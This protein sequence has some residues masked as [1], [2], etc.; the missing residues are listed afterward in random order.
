MNSSLY[1]IFLYAAGTSLGSVYLSVG[2]WLSL[3]LVALIYILCYLLVL[4]ICNDWWC[5]SF[6]GSCD[7]ICLVWDKCLIDLE[8]ISMVVRLLNINLICF[9]IFLQLVLLVS[10]LK[11]RL[12]SKWPIHNGPWSSLTIRI[13]S[14]S[15]HSCV[16]CSRKVAHWCIGMIGIGA[17]M[18]VDQRIRFHRMILCILI[19]LRFW[20][21][22][23][24]TIILVER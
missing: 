22:L 11:V 19:E 5:H 1:Y 7:S 4:I 24:F 14:I 13:I 2:A 21:E 3:L 23:F 17:N 8:V 10:W 16:S 18:T 20:I 12:Q 9:R 15:G 6:F